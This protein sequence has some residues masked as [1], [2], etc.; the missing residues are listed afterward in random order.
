MKLSKEQIIALAPDSSSVKAA[1]KLKT[2][3][4][5]PVLAYSKDAIWGHCQGSGK[6][7]YAVCIDLKETAFKCSCPSRKFPCKHALALYLLHEAGS[8]RETEM[9][10][11]TSEWLEKRR[12]REQAKI[13]RAQNKKSEAID[14]AKQQKKQAARLNIMRDGLSECEAWLRDMVTLGLMT[15]PNMNDD[16]W[17]SPAARL[18]DAKMPGAA[19]IIQQM[20]KVVQS[21]SVN[22]IENFTMLIGKLYGIIQSFKNYEELNSDMQADLRTVAGWSFEKN[23]VL[24]I[25]N[26]VNGAWVVV[27]ESITE[28][29]RIREQRIWLC[30][31]KTNRTALMLNFAFG[32]QPLEV[33]MTP[34]TCFK[35]DISY[36]PG[37]MPMRAIIKKRLGDTKAVRNFSGNVSIGQALSIIAGSLAKNPWASIHPMML[38]GVTPYLKENTLVIG[39]K[40]G[41]CLTIDPLFAESYELLAISGG[42]KIT[43]SGEFSNQLFLPLGCW[44]EGRFHNFKAERFR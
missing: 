4:K 3:A 17:T 35:A 19:G 15:L 20:H 44:S 1:E 29:K 18:V 31:E 36:Y 37:T 16:Y 23:E 34:G 5:W 6:K 40:E 21:S 28:D 7:P 32:R 12:Q 10:D 24:A 13:S 26:T 43:I 42:R 11:W 22:W 41:R 25:D 8:T 14:P 33:S 30:E 9:A 2:P 38:S 39:D 27:G